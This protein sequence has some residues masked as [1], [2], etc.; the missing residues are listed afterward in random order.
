MRSAGIAI[1]P[2]EHRMAP[3]TA[4]SGQLTVIDNGEIIAHGEP[5]VIQHNCRVIVACPG[6]AAG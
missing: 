1:I 3:V 5:G 6:K 4:I 2:V